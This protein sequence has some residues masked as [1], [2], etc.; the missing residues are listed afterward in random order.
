MLKRMRKIMLILLSVLMLHSL[1][2]VRLH[3]DNNESTPSIVSN[4]EVLFEKEDGLIFSIGII[5]DG[6]YDVNRN[7][8]GW[9]SDWNSPYTTSFDLVQSFEFI[10]KPAEGY[11]FKGWYEAT[12]DKHNN[13]T[14]ITDNLISTDNPYSTTLNSN[15]FIAAVF[16]EGVTVT[17]NTRGDTSIEPQIIN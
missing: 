17:F 16:I 10:A 11:S 6:H 15:L 2:P 12:V 3:A 1:L 7:G 4:N 5:G 13:V 9:L 14:G 8:N